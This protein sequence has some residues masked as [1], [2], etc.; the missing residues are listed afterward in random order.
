MDENLKYSLKIILI[1]NIQK[2][3]K[4]NQSFSKENQVKTTK[5]VKTRQ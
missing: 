4:I 5:I 1:R 2:E 3:V